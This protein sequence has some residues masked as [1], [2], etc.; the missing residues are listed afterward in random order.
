MGTQLRDTTRETTTTSATMVATTQCVYPQQVL[1]QGHWHYCTPE[2]LPQ[3]LQQSY[4]PIWRGCTCRYSILGQLQVETAQSR[5]EIKGIW[6]G[7]DPT[8]DEHLI[9]FHQSTTIIHRLQV[10]STSAEVS[11]GYHD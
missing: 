1:G 4:L 6:I 8:T 10:L 7:K 5:P 9:A 3:G 2:Q 11:L